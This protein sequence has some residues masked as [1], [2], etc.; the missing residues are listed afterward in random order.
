MR[1]AWTLYEQGLPIAT[2]EITE[3]ARLED[4]KV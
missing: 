1:I 4:Y 2:K 3:C